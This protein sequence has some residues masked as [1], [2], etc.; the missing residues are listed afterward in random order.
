MAA[1]SFKNFT[2]AALLWCF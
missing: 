2:N 1:I